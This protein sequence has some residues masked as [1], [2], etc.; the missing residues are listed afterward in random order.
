[1]YYQPKADAVTRR[2]V[3]LEGLIRWRSPDLGLVSPAE[4][5]PLMEETGMIL[6]VGAWVLERAAR[7]QR[8]WSDGGVHLRVAVNVS[9]IQLRQRDFVTAVKQALLNGRTP[10][11]TDRWR[12]FGPG[13]GPWR[14]R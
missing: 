5:I 2:I 12:C 4:F 6:D 13:R 11:C 3:G 7:D 1:M 14:C 10:P 9:A 8:R